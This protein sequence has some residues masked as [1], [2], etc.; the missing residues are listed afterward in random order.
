M[1]E[2]TGRTAE[3]WDDQAAAPDSPMYWTQYPAVRSYVNECMTGV[4]WAYPTHGFKAGWAYRPL[5]RGLSIGCGT[6]NLERDLR[7]LRICEEADAYD[8]SAASIQIARQRARDEQIDRVNFAVA[9]CETIVYPEDRYDAVF[10][11][12]SLHHISNPDA[13]LD[14]LLPSLRAGG[15]LYVDDYVGP[16]RDEWISDDLAFAQEA[17]DTLPETWRFHERVGIPYDSDD[18]SEMIRSSRIIPA[19]KERFAILYERPYWGNVLYPLLCSVNEHEVKSDDGS[20]LDRLIK[21]EKDL[22][23]SGT[24]R[25]PL[26]AWIVARKK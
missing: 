4:W 25:K 18:P 13:L 17:Y 16:S 3:F 20:V 14:R 1:D 2:F 11:H 12:G 5:A 24:L 22:V 21:F 9:D 15:L 23:S 8:L 19:L 26:F 6:G 7:L 10:F